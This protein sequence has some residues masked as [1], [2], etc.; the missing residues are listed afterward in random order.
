MDL[1]RLVT[2]FAYKIEPK[3]DGGFIARASD[4]SVPPLEAPTREELTQKIQQNILASLSA[5]FPNLKLPPEGNHVQMSF[6]VERTPAGGFEIH[7]AD[8]N[9][10]VIH[11][12]SQQDFESKFLN[13]FVNFAGQHMMA[14]LAKGVAAQGSIG[15]VTVTVNRRTTFRA[16]SGPAAAP[17]LDAAAQPGTNPD[18]GA[19]LTSSQPITPESSSL[20]F[21]LLALGCLALLIILY[22]ARR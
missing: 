13:K 4:P 18:L 20:R 15:N 22:W 21:F 14:E 10:G 6:H 16:K 7:S 9:A 17:A 11:A 12:D 2:H 5:E 1:K 3:P 8:P 19:S